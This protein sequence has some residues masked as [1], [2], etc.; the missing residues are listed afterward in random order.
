MIRDASTSTHVE[1][2]SKA[3]T[4]NQPKRTALTPPSGD[5]QPDRLAGKEPFMMRLRESLP[6][7]ESTQ[8]HSLVSFFGT[9]P[10]LRTES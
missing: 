5:G 2:T 6:P 10:R 7:A 8:L 3:T 1:R 4:V 9:F